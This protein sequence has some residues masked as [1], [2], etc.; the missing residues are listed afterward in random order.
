MTYDI[1]QD[2]KDNINSVIVWN[3][4]QNP[5]IEFIILHFRTA[6]IQV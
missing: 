3:E 6:I 4:G 1:K 5:S 2:K